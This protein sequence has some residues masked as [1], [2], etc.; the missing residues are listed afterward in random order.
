M[1]EENSHILQLLLD[2]LQ[3]DYDEIIDQMNHNLVKM[4]EADLFTSSMLENEDSN[5]KFFS[6]L[7]NN[8]ENR[9]TY[10]DIIDTSAK[11][12]SNRLRACG[13]VRGVTP[14]HSKGHRGHKQSR[15]TRCHI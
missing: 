6:R 7:E 10:R 13:K 8:Y 3:K 1:K 15:H 4:Q 2:E 11:G 5:F 14:Y 12:Q 9:Q